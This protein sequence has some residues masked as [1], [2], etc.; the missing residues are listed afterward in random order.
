MTHMLR[1][2]ENDFGCCTEYSVENREGL[3]LYTRVSV[4]RGRSKCPTVLYRTPY[5]SVPEQISPNP[6][7]SFL[8][9]GY[10]VI[11][12]HCRGRGGSEGECIPYLHEGEDSLDLIR[13]AC[14]LPHFNGELYLS[15]GSYGA[16]VWLMLPEVPPE[17]RGA[18]LEIQTDR[19]Y[20]RHYVNGLVRSFAGAEW[21]FSMMS[22]S[23]PRL[24]GISGA[25]IYRRPY[26]DIVKRALGVRVP[27]FEQALLHDRQDGYWTGMSSHTIMEKIHCPVLLADG[28]YDY[29]THGMCSMWER[30][31]SKTREKSCF[32]MGPYGHGTRVQ[33]SDLPLPHGDLPGDYRLQWLEHLRT[34]KPYPYATPGSFRYY[35][36]G[37]DQ[38]KEKRLLSF[39]GKERVGGQDFYFSADKTLRLQPPP[40]AFCSWDYDPEQPCRCFASNR[41]CRAAPPDS[42]DGVLSFESDLFRQ[43]TDYF[44]C[45]RFSLWVS[46]TAEDTAFY[47]R[48]YLVRSGEAYALGEIAGALLALNPSAKPETP[49][50]I[51]MHTHPLAFTLLPGD[52][53]R[54][55]LA[56]SASEFVPHANIKGHWAEVTSSEPCRNTV[57][58]GAS[59]MTLYPD[60][61]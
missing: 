59:R 55:D 34:G 12:Q 24:P 14:T 26:K 17:V 31:P 4:P 11:T 54:V 30:M 38:W 39:P 19:L 45:A 47:L 1:Q 9:A 46:S 51:E 52:R 23:R 56:S 13:F 21:Q 2:C 57:Y 50:L 44:G 25:Q 60:Q 10:A 8:C 40:Q 6:G 37:A 18:I 32:L 42:V 48:L 28:W 36:V 16:T 3:H 58:F 5:E 27:Y 7:D 35:S 29:Y 20:D 53:L 15:G 33:N 61:P 43:K 49:S 41:L 22:R